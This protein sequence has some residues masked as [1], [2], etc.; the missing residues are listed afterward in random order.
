MSRLGSRLSRLAHLPPLLAFY[1]LLEV[2]PFSAW[3]SVSPLT[4]VCSRRSF[5]IARRHALPCRFARPDAGPR[6]NPFPANP[7]NPLV[8]PTTLGASAGA[9]LA[10][11]ATTLYAPSFLDF[12]RTEIALIGAALATLLVFGLAWRSALLPIPL[13]LS[14]LMISLFAGACGALRPL[15]HHDYL[16]SVFIWSAGSLVQKIGAKPFICCLASL[17]LRYCRCFS[18]GHCRSLG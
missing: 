8:E 15:F 1:R 17:P 2:L 13:I 7:R 6:R 4:T 12:G 11:I 3:P 18:S 16:Q 14:G 5:S 10:L 9:Q